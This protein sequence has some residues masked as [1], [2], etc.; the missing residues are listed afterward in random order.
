MLGVRTCGAPKEP[1]AAVV[2]ETQR[3]TFHVSP[4]SAKGLLT[5]Q[6]RDALKAN[7]DACLRLIDRENPTRSELL[8]SDLR[9][10]GRGPSK[11]RLP[12]THASG[13]R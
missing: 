10:H 1:P 13:K 3:L 11:R 2:G 12:A 7:L 4:L 6:T 8:A 9:P 5:Q